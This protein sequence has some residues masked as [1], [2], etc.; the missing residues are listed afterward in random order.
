MVASRR[1]S[2]ATWPAPSQSALWSAARFP[3]TAQTRAGL[4]ATSVYKVAGQA[5]RLD[6]RFQVSGYVLSTKTDKTRQRAL[7]SKDVRFFI[8][9]VESGG[10][11]GWLVDDWFARVNVGLPEVDPN[12]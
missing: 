10:K 2:S 1:G 12:P 9:P 11:D 3:Y 4:A 5:D 7:I 8:V 6:I